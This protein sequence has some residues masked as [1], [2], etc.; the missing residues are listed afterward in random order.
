[1]PN[2]AKRWCFTLNNYTE[3]DVQTLRTLGG[4]AGTHY[5]VF[6]R[7]VADSGTAHLQCFAIFDRRH[8]LAWC[9]TNISSRAHFEIARGSAAQAS[10]YC[11]KDGDFE[12]FGNIPNRPAGRSDLHAVHQAIRD[13][14]TASQIEESFPGPFIR[15]RTNIL[16]CIR[17]RQPKRTWAM[18]VFVLWGRSGAGKTRTVFDEHGYN[19]IYVHT[20]SNWFDGYE[21]HEIALF[22]DFTGSEFKLGYL[23]KLL[24]RYPMMVPV[25]GGFVQWVPKKI[26]FTSNKDPHDWYANAIEQHQEALFRRINTIQ[27]FD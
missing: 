11:K 4:D 1:M 24:D 26:Y 3:E 10:Q 20:G 8:T 16:A 6:G 15:Y 9:R 13:G 19:A 17:E 14:Q 22:D 7:E 23:L 12:E 27:H 21:G 5:L 18:E 2:G 25:K